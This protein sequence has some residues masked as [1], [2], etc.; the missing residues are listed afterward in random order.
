MINDRMDLNDWLRKQLGGSRP[1]PAAGDG[2]AE[3]LMS[4]DAD[5]TCGPPYGTMSPRSG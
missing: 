5:D 4:A 2:F 3:S 1:G